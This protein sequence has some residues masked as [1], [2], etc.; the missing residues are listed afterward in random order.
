MKLG[1]ERDGMEPGSH[2]AGTH[3]NGGFMAF[4]RSRREAS[5]REELGEFVADGC[6]V[7]MAGAQDAGAVGDHLAVKRLGFG[8]AALARGQ[9]GQHGAG[10]EGV[11]V[12]ITE[13]AVPVGEHLPA[14]LLGLGVAALGAEHPGHSPDGR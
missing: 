14:E 5:A 8:A 2:H 12:V 9:P 10:G 1:A 11:R 3:R 13:D 4:R 6:G 7:G